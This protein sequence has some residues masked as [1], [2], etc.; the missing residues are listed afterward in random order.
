MTPTMRNHKTMT[1]T[2]EKGQLG[3]GIRTGPPN[4]RRRPHG[5]YGGLSMTTRPLRGRGSVAS[6]FIGSTLATDEHVDG[7][8]RLN[9]NSLQQPVSRRRLV[10]A[11]T[12]M[13][14]LYTPLIDKLG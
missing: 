5:P 2:D 13:A 11:R 12:V 4:S 3:R 9:A 10:L 8:T 6:R 1:A 7:S 14:L